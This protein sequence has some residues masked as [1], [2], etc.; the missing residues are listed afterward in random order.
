MH[1]MEK[2]VL[3]SCK[4]I[5]KNFGPTRAL[6]NVDFEIRRGEICGLIG[7]NGSGKSTL[8]SIFAGIQPAVS[9][10]MFRAGEEYHPANMLEAQQKGVAIIVQEA[11]TLPSMDVAANVFVGNFQKFRRG[12]F[13]DVKRMHVEANKILD[14]IGASDIRANTLVSSLNFEDR[15]IVEIARAMY[16]K[17]DVIIIDETTTA[18]A[19]KGRTLIYNLIKKFE[20]EG[21]AVIF[22]SHDLDELAEVC[23]SI[24]VLRDGPCDFSA[25]G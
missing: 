3:L 10:K 16:L 19:Q 7:E 20:A 24:V 22:I 4:E 14:E 1:N 12:G 5:F 21:K 25:R 8:T 13:L 2:E 11:G 9:G 15:K 6:V 18:L 17:P 23:N